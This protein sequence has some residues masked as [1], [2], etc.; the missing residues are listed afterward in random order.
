[1]NELRQPPE[2][3]QIELASLVYLLGGMAPK[4]LVAIGGLVPPLLVPEAPSPH[5]GSADIQSQP[6]T[7]A[8]GCDRI[9]SRRPR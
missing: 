4:H 8:S 5:R 6:P 7:P 3:M 9:R 1:L 2:V